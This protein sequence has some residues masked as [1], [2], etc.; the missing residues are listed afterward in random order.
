MERITSILRPEWR[1][2]MFNQ[3]RVGKIFLRCPNQ[4]KSLVEGR[5][6][7]RK[8][9]VG[10]YKALERNPLGT[11]ETLRSRRYQLKGRLLES[12]CHRKYVFEEM[13]RSQWQ[14]MFGM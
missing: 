13:Q 11:L 5:L 4:K 7:W 8:N 9:W 10:R 3:R 14:E 12:L 1:V 2:K 6:Y